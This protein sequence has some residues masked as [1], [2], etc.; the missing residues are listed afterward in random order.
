MARAVHRRGTLTHDR[1]RAHH[2]SAFTLIEVLVVVAIIALLIAILLPS[3]NAAREL[4]RRSVC[5]SNL[6]QH[7]LANHC[8]L[9][10]N[11]DYLA[12]AS[13]WVRTS[14][15]SYYYRTDWEAALDTYCQWSGKQGFEN[16]YDWQKR[17]VNRYFYVKGLVAADN[18]SGV[19]EIFRC[20]SDNGATPCRWYGQRLPT[21]FDDFGSSY[22]YNS[23]ANNNDPVK[24][25]W[26]KRVS[27]VKRPAKVILAHCWPVSAWG[28][29]D[30]SWGG[31]AGVNQSE[32]F[33]RSYWHRPRNQGE[34]WGNMLFNDTH[35]GFRQATRTQPDFQNGSDWSFAFNG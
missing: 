1:A 15:G 30:G 31:P 32:P 10:D 23:T 6:S 20:P 5:A 7:G 14:N 28:W 24:G 26:A 33:T 21:M 27:Q 3:I 13:Q 22:F 12:S 2:G 11:R 16:G 18:N 35:V 25:L 17:F 34:G 29:P 8:Y 19:F 4:S 9:Q